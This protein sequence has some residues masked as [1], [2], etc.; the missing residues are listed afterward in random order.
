[1]YLPFTSPKVH[2]KTLCLIES[3][4]RKHSW[5]SQYLSG[6]PFPRAKRTTVLEDASRSESQIRSP[7][8]TKWHEQETSTQKISYERSWSYTYLLIHGL[9]PLFPGT[10]QICEND[11]RW[12]SYSIN[13]KHYSISEAICEYCLQTMPQQLSDRYYP[14]LRN[15]QTFIHL[16][17]RL[18][19]QNTPIIIVRSPWVRKSRGVDI[20]FWI[21]RF[22]GQLP[23]QLASQVLV[24]RNC[25]TSYFN[26]LYI[27]A[28]LQD[29]LTRMLW[30]EVDAFKAS[31]RKAVAYLC[32]LPMLW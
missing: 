4:G 32:L 18:T 31:V 10:N 27:V 29:S 11:H 1:M 14:P 19:T 24:H 30:E 21:L 8:H 15:P 9:A 16:T 7:D 23:L 5:F 6:N 26:H 20:H 17:R 25:F 2:G 12:P 28:M 3:Q 22:K 13:Q